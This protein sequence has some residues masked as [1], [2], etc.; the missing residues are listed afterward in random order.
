MQYLLYSSIGQSWA[1]NYPSGRQGHFPG[2]SGQVTNSQETNE[3]ELLATSTQQRLGHE[4]TSQDSE[5]K[6]GTKHTYMTQA[7][8]QIFRAMPTILENDLN[9][10]TSI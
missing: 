2:I 6:Q 3:S 10:L 9:L 4:C 7:Q 5:T 1:V 8:K